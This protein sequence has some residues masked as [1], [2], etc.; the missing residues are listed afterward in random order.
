MIRLVSRPD[1]GQD[2]N[3]VSG[4]DILGPLHSVNELREL[5]VTLQHLL[6]S[7]RDTFMM[8]QLFTS[9]FPSDE[10]I[11]RICQDL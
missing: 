10:N 2:Y 1:N 5:G 3:S 8:P 11:Q 9:A 6:N 4:Q 7:T